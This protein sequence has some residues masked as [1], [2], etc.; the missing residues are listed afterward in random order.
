MELRELQ[1]DSPIELHLRIQVRPGKRLAFLDFLGEAVPVYESPGGIRVR[2]LEDLSND[3]RFIEVVCYDDESAY[4][5][6]QER[7]AHDPEVKRLLERWRALLVRPPE[8]EVYRS[9]TL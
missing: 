8:V 4:W 7:I 1:P 3:H 6:D 2:L 9:R 5:Q